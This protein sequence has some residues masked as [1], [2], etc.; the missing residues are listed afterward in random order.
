MRLSVC[1]YVWVRMCVCVCT[2]TKRRRNEE[3]ARLKYFWDWISLC[4][5][6]LLV[7]SS[8]T[9]GWCRCR[10]VRGCTT[11]MFVL[12]T[13]NTCR[14]SYWFQK[15]KERFIYS[16]SGLH[17]RHITEVKLSVSYK[18]VN[19]HILALCQRWG[20]T[21]MVPRHEY[22]ILLRDIRGKGVTILSNT[23]E[24]PSLINVTCSVN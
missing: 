19:C 7:L 8:V 22:C 21:I 9:D 1:V 2:D 5:Y 14:D 23:Q 3:K 18:L 10:K 16:R 12:Q 11:Q 4:A 13:H 6:L 17:N 15:G 24:Q 20:V